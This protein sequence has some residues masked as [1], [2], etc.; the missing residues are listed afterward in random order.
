MFQQKT[1]LCIEESGLWLHLSG[2]SG[3]EMLGAYPDG[4]VGRNA[5]LEVKCPFTQ[6]DFTIEE[7]VLSDDFYIQKNAE[8]HYELKKDMSTGIKCRD[9]YISVKGRPVFLLYGQQKK[10]LF[11]KSRKTLHGLTIF[12]IYRTF[13][14]VI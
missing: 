14:H 6:R 10:P 8:G 1:N 5:L 2:H 3:G 13:T 9:N 12:V 4:L 11:S 7:A